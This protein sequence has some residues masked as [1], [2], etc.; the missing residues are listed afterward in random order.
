MT[1]ER[2]PDTGLKIAMSHWAPG[3]SVG[4]ERYLYNW[5]D[6]PGRMCELTRNDPHDKY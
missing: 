4:I 1:T 2:I 5:R 3:L 6:A